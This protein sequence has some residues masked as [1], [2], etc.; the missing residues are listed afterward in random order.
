MDGWTRLLHSSEVTDAEVPTPRGQLLEP[1]RRFPQRYFGPAREGLGGAR[2]GAVGKGFDR[3]RGM[4]LDQRDYLDFDLPIGTPPAVAFLTTDRVWRSGE[5]KSLE[6]AAAKILSAHRFP[7]N[8]DPYADV[9]W[10]LLNAHVW[11]SWRGGPLAPPDAVPFDCRDFFRPSAS[12]PPGSAFEWAWRVY[13]SQLVCRLGR[14]GGL[15]RDWEAGF[16]LGSYLGLSEGRRRYG[17]EKRSGGRPAPAWHAAA[18]ERAVQIRRL[19]PEISQASLADRLKTDCATAHLPSTGQVQDA[20]RMW[21]Q[22]GLLQRSSK[23]P[24]IRVP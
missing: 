10:V 16:D 24:M 15:L 12:W 20:I 18:L 13:F 3:Q 2:E 14:T 4:V 11:W 7:L 19:E 1:A 22:S 8:C 6:T 5:R 9:T 23:N 21:E 17:A